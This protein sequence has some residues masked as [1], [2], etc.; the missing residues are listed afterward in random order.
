MQPNVLLGHLAN[1]LSC[2]NYWSFFRTDYDALPPALIST[3]CS[4]YDF[5][6][7]SLYL[8]LST[9]KID[10][11]KLTL[12]TFSRRNRPHIPFYL[13]FLYYNYFVYFTLTF[14]FLSTFV[15][16][17]I[18]LKCITGGLSSRLCFKGVSVYSSYRR[19]QSK[20]FVWKPLS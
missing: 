4:W 16:P 5:T 17:C 8:I 2:T 15:D 1:P 18:Q 11:Y 12:Y 6:Y 13:A 10:K 7:N 20:K 3:L 14:P 19:C 9:W